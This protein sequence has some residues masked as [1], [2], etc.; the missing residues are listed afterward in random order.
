MRDRAG[1]E[2]PVEIETEEATSDAD[3]VASHSRGGAAGAV[4]AAQLALERSLASIQSDVALPHA[5]ALTDRVL[6]AIFD[7]R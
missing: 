2:R 1:A 3:A 5:P 7:R 4:A 6:A